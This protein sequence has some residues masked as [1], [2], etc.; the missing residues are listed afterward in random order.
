MACGLYEIQIG[1]YFYHGSSNNI[2]RRMS[3]HKNKLKNKT[4]EN[5]KMQNIFNKYK[6]FKHEVILTCKEEDLLYLEQ[7]II[8]AHF[9]DKA[10]MNIALTAGKPPSRKGAEISEE[11]KIKLSAAGLGNKRSLGHKQTEEHK[12]NV[13][14]SGCRR[15]RSDET[16]AKMSAAGKLRKHSEESK[17]KMAA[18]AKARW[19]KKNAS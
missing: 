4:H 14:A 6:E 13:T 16:K 1:S 19:E 3:A 7:C 2:E 10:Y 17:L 11:T 8:D 15:P 9:E 18:S 12:A 5:P